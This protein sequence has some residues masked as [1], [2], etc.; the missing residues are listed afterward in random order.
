MR[1]LAPLLLLFAAATTLG[2]GG[3]LS[4]PQRLAG[5]WV[6]RPESAAERTTREWPTGDLD[7]DDP[8][9]A[10]AAAATPPTDLEAFADVRVELRL[11]DSGDARLTLAGGEPLVGKWK[12]TSVEGR[13]A[14][15]EI[16]VERTGDEE[17]TLESRRFDIELLPRGEGFVLREQGAD[18]RFGRLLFLRPGAIKTAADTPPNKSAI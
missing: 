3:S 17:P 8:E 1:R 4:L 12:A 6:G 14:L 18:R 2:C 11:G 5:D 9:I 7:P 15:L 16:G 10:A 13:R